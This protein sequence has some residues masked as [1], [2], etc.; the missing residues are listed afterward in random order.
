MNLIITPILLM[1][2][3]ITPILLMN[4]IITPILLMNLIITP[5]PTDYFNVL[6]ADLVTKAAFP[7]QI[8][9]LVVT[10]NGE[11]EY[12]LPSTN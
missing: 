6:Y 7:M 10:Y 9:R 4:L 1:N 3:I 8:N 2:L 11:G 12:L 5:I